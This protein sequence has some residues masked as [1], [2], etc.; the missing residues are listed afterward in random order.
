MAHRYSTG[1]RTFFGQ[2]PLPSGYDA[3]R[4]S[5][6]NVPPVGLE[7]ADRALFNLFDREI[8]L[9]TDSA[10][11]MRKVPIIFA[12]A[13]KWAMIK[14][15][16]FI[17]DRTGALIVPLIAIVRSNV[18]QTPS[19]DLAGRGINQQT[20]ELIVHRRLSDRDRGH[21]SVLNRLL[22]PNQM[23]AAVPPEG[24]LEGQLTTLATVGDRHDEGVVIDGG[25]LAADRTR[26][27]WE[28]IVVP[29][30]QFFTSTYE[31]TIWTQYMQQ[32]N[33]VIEQLISSFLPQGNA[34]RLETAAGYWFMAYVDGN[35][36]SADVNFDD[37][38]SE[39]RIIKSSFTV[40]V[41]S[42]VFAS[43]TPGAPVAVRRYLSSPA[44][45]FEVG[46]SPDEGSEPGSVDDPFLGADDPTLPSSILRIG[47]R[48]D[49]R[50]VGATRLYP[51][52][53]SAEDPALASLGRGRTTARFRKVTGVAIDGSLVTRY[54]RVLN[55]N[56][57]SGEVVYGPSDL[58][59]LLITAID[60]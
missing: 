7:D 13:E 11:G 21:Q 49:Q 40:K 6:V 8:P 27:V 57:H 19:E 17:Q 35:L 58:G 52:G 45:S 3:P 25:L 47:K 5:D 31:V 42:Y 55:V 50:D 39:E 53:E 28:T 15:G 32:M 1:S 48:P 30:P 34:W 20:G 60:D 51:D 56:R 59:D 41:P 16:R 46:L 26:N 18:S 24:A 38:S 10:S 29:S 37:M 4:P 23:N 9:Q 44:I 22:V 36:Y 12:G 33:Q 14:R 2:A 43:R 54:V